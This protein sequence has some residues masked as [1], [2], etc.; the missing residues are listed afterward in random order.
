MAPARMS[1]AIKSFTIRIGVLLFCF[2]LS[3][4]II[5][6]T[7]AKSNTP[8]KILREK[9]P[10]REKSCDVL[11]RDLPKGERIPSFFVP[12]SQKNERRGLFLS[13]LCQKG[14]DFPLLLR[15]FPHGKKS[16]IG[17]EE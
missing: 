9:L 17:K 8:A 2:F 4:S 15:P 3:A 5:A 14:Q 11:R 6:E 13:F 16:K 12:R 7:V 10:F 1:R